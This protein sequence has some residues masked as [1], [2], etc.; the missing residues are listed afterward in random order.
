MRLAASPV[1]MLVCS[2]KAAVAASFTTSFG[3]QSGRW[4]KRDTRS[5]QP[6]RLKKPS[7][8]VSNSR[9]TSCGRVLKSGASYAFTGLRSQRGDPRGVLPP[10]I[11]ACGYRIRGRSAKPLAQLPIVDQARDGG[12]HAGWA[13]R[14]EQ[15][16]RFLRVEHLAD[17]GLIGRHDR[18]SAR[19]V[20]E[21]LQG[22]CVF[23]ASGLQRDVECGNV[24]PDLF[25]AHQPRKRDAVRYAE[26]GRLR[27]ERG[28]GG[29]IADD[30]QMRVA[31]LGAAKCLDDQIQPMPFPHESRKPQDDPVLEAEPR[32]GRAHG[33]FIAKE[34]RRVDGVAYHFYLS[35]RDAGSL[36]LGAQDRGDG[37]DVIG[38]L[39]DFSL[40]RL[41]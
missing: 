7:D 20:F 41:G 9:R 6:G 8:A 40:K 15:E 13:G 30:D 10:G 19:H 17:V 39:P 3:R 12:K 29:T 37:K 5:Y 11:A 36:Y 27:L 1:R 18:L 14:V 26:I 23:H 34:F 16:R 33:A 35:R 4:L 32:L 2:A 24:V 28:Y 38:G 31:G 22:R 25:A 21:E